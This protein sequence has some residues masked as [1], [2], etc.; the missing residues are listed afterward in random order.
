MNASS[1]H[2][3]GVRVCSFLLLCFLS[4]GN[5]SSGVRHTSESRDLLFGRWKCEFQDGSWIIVRRSDGSFEK[6]GKMVETI[7]KPPIHYIVSGT[8]RLEGNHYIE[9]WKKAS[10]ES[11]K[12]AIGSV[13]RAEVLVIQPDRF[14]RIQRESPVLIELRVGSSKA[15]SPKAAIT[16]KRRS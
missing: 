1:L 5:S 2:F 7:G 11:W 10:P 12:S 13:F 14:E 3:C 6:D 8:W 16:S 15:S 4:L 9:V